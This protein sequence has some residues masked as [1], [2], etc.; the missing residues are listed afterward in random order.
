MRFQKLQKNMLHFAMSLI[1]MW[2]CSN[3]ASCLFY[4]Y[5]Y[6]EVKIRTPIEFID[7]EYVLH[8]TDGKNF[9]SRVGY[10]S[11]NENEC[12]GKCSLSKALA[13][14]IENVMQNPSDLFWD[15][16]PVPDREPL[17]IV[18]QKFLLPYIYHDVSWQ[19]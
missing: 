12:K 17:L 10:K 3:L 1:Q 13:I 14:R 16:T 4:N 18:F 19:H 2:Y 5:L 15:E 9:I 6:L 7:I 8:L 11:L